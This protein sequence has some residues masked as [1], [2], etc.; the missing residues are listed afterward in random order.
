MRTDSTRVADDAIAG[1]REL[2]A[3]TYGADSLPE[4]PNVFKSK[5]NA[6]DAHE[7][8]RPTSFDLPP[9]RVRELPQ[10]RE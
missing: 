7:A 3:A 1:G 4:K 5:K 10:G 8:I 2:I 9:G 6:Q